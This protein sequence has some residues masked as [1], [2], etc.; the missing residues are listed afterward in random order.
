MQVDD[1]A[2]D[3][4]V[5]FITPGFFGPRQ[6]IVW[7][8]TN[9]QN[10]LVTATIQPQDGRLAI[11]SVKFDQQPG[12]QPVQRAAVGKIP[13]DNFIRC[14]AERVLMQ[15]TDEE[16]DQYSAVVSSELPDGS[17]TLAV[18]ARGVIHALNDTKGHTPT[19]DEDYR[20]IAL[21]YR[22]LRILEGKPTA[23]LAEHLGVSRATM[24]R[25]TS[26]AADRGFLTAEE[27]AH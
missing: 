8:D 23:M 25:W 24:K 15:I 18:P 16:A 9:D 11:V 14:A 5:T 17:P 1:D 19:T 21:L 20:R 27:R 22:W 10:Y 6:T 2:T 3:S 13:L 12:Q 26:K 4:H 7:D